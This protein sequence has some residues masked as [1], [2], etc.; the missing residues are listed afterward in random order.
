MSLF[1]FSGPAV[2][3]DIHAVK[4]DSMNVLQMHIDHPNMKN[5]P[6]QDVNDPI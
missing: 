3:A 4:G 5:L 6:V 2:E 1:F